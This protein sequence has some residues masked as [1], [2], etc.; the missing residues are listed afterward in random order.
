MA[1]RGPPLVT[2]M[3][4]TMFEPSAT[5]FGVLLL[6]RRRSAPSGRTCSVT[7]P[8]SLPAS[9]SGVSLVM[10][11]VLVKGLPAAATVA[12]AVATTLMSSVAPTAKLARVH[13][14]A[15][16]VALQVQ[17]VPVAETKA[18]SGALDRLRGG[19]DS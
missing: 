11:A 10:A 17:P 4:E 16:P 15:W 13:R 8:P 7:A 18:Q 14:T 12:G 5:G 1:L 9:P 3:V 6:A 2:V 19:L